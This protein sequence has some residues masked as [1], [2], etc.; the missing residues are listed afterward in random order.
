MT[1]VLKF[2]KSLQDINDALDVLHN[3]ILG[4]FNTIVDIIKDDNI[5]HFLQQ[6]LP[7][8]VKE[9]QYYDI[10]HQKLQHIKAVHEW[11]EHGNESCAKTHD[12]AD[13]TNLVRLN[14]LQFQLSCYDYTSAV[15][16]IALSM[17]SG[18]STLQ[19]SPTGTLNV[20]ENTTNIL[21]QVDLVNRKLQEAEEFLKE[22]QMV[23][24]HV[25]VDRLTTLYSMECE[26]AVLLAYLDNPAIQPEEIKQV[27][28]KK[29]TDQ[30]IE[31]F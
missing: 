26:R 27:V 6:K 7:L 13:V 5:T 28:R 22:L 17:T 18:F 11:I 3:Y 12:N 30:S 20:F 31:L 8:I 1:N 16:M 19:Y 10:I 24:T 2:I 14:F 15:S 4:D 21:D 25:D 29:S 23:C 9:L